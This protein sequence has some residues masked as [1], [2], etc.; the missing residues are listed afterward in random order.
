MHLKE[1]QEKYPGIRIKTDEIEVDPTMLVEHALF[2]RQNCDN[3]RTETINYLVKHKIDG[4]ST[5]NNTYEFAKAFV[6]ISCPACKE[7]MKVNTGSG[8][9]NTH[10]ITYKCS[11]GTKFYLTIPNNGFS[12]EFP[13]E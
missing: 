8:N 9:S 10:T 13:K 5:C 11:C 12:F 1:F 4:H 2:E 6:K 7:E 3:Y